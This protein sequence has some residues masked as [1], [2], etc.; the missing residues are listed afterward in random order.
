MSS[1]MSTHDLLAR[2]ARL[3]AVIGSWRVMASCKVVKPWDGRGDGLPLAS[4]EA[5]A[6]SW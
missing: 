3:I 2:S 4:A 5:K 1:L 6:S